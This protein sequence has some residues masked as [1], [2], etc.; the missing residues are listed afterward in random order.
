[1]K[2]SHGAAVGPVEEEQKFYFQ[3]RGVPPEEAENIIVQG[4]FEPVIAAIPSE[5]TQDRLRQVID[6]KLRRRAT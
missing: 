1:M 6:D 5:E 3:T 4:F 2:C